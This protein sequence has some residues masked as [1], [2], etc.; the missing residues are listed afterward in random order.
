MGKEVP[1]KLNGEVI[2]HAIV[3]DNGA[4]DAHVSPT[5]ELGQTVIDKLNRGLISGLSYDPQQEAAEAV[6]KD[7]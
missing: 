5:T 4:I 1:L 7:A 3:H 6:V 2:G